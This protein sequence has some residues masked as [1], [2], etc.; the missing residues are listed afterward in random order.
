MKMV[1]LAALFLAAAMLLTSVCFATDITGITVER[2]KTEPVTDMGTYHWGVTSHKLSDADRALIE[3]VVMAEAGGCVYE[4]M[5]GVAQVI[6]E[7]AESWG[8]TAREVVTARAQFA[9]P[10][11]GEVSENAK[12]AVSAV[13]D[14][15]ERVFKEYTTHFHN[16]S[17]NP[18]WNKYKI[19]RGEIDSQL[20][21]GVEA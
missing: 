13:F 18:W 1:R 12:K 16:T 8:M 11:S 17:V 5:V 4:G 20:F 3:R 2:K 15:G 10:Y 14:H 7:R 21:W 9:A 19:F 6:R